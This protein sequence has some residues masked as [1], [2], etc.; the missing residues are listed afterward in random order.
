MSCS[1]R[2]Y[3]ASMIQSMTGVLTRPQ[4]RF[5]PSP[6]PK[7]GA[8]FPEQRLTVESNKT[9][10]L[11]KNLPSRCLCLRQ[12]VILVL[13][14]V[15]TTPHPFGEGA[16]SPIFPKGRGVCTQA[17]QCLCLGQIVISVLNTYQA[18]RIVT[19]AK[20]TSFSL[21]LLHLDK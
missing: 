13:A 14:C 8:H 20:M 2:R 7:L 16:P 18:W 3:F 15:H 9:L 17:I 1:H 12:I 10:A 21:T 6:G 11:A 19:L 5:P 4:A